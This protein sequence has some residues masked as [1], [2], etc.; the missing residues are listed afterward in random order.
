M[1]ATSSSHAEES[2]ADAKPKARGQE[3]L[4][5]NGEAGVEIANLRTFDAN[6]DTLTVGLTPTKGVGPAFG[7]GAGVR[8]SFITLGARAR[9]AAMQASG[10]SAWQLW[11]LD[12]ELG[13]HAPLGRIEP[14][15]SLAGGYAYLGNFGTAAGG[16][17]SGF[18]VSGANLRLGAGLDVY[19]TRWFSIGGLVSG[20]MLIL[21]RQGVSLADLA[22]AK[23]IGTIDAAKARVLEANGTSFGA[24]L[25]FALVLGLHY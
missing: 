13:F 4:W 12:A 3:W 24:A 10:G 2:S 23:Q 18:D 9:M 11:T 15:L 22:A 14:Y 6:V 7:L 8:L 1:L 5:L 25:T 21:A 16:L 19:A 20:E 17:S